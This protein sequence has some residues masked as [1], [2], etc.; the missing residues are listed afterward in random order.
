MVYI[1][2][3]LHVLEV[4]LC[5]RLHAISLCEKSLRRWKMSQNVG[6]L[7]QPAAQTSRESSQFDATGHAVRNAMDR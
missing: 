4:D 5:S 7:N 2:Y 1:W 6:I 3:V